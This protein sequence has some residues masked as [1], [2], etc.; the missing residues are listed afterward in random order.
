MANFRRIGALAGVL[1]SCLIASVAQS[2]RQ[3]WITS[4]A[5]A[6]VDINNSTEAPLFAA[7]GAPSHF[8][9]QTIRNIVHLTLGGEKIRVRLSNKFGT[10]PVTFNSVSVGLQA[11]GAQL[12]AISSRPVTF[13][14]ENS[15]TLPEGTEVFSDAIALPVKSGQNL[16][17]SLFTAGETGPAT[18]HAG[19]LQTNFIS[20]A[21]D[22]SA[23]ENAQSFGKTTQSWYFL[24]GVDVLPSQAGKGAIVALGDSITDGASARTDKNE[25]WTDVLAQ[26]LAADQRAYSV[27][28]AGIGGNRVLS[29][30]PCFGEN[31]IARLPRDVFGHFGVVAII[32]FEGTNDI[33][34]PDTHPPAE[35][36]PC[37]A[38]THV[39][40]EEIIAGYLQII[41]QAHARGIKV[42]GATILPFQGYRGWTAKGEATRVAVNNWIRS[43]NGFDGVIDF[44]LALRDPD[45]SAKFAPAYDSGDHLHPGPAGHKKMGE[46]VS[47]QLFP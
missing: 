7:S 24:Q 1:L 8:K 37:L 16:A 19:A 6:N 40:A 4:W 20:A 15:V 18:V 28:N 14:G 39:T 32:L 36:S 2:G 30:S 43:R 3:A 34:Q 25:R 42:F 21:G 9:N 26:R 27:L 10:Q 44:D 46:A 13:A 5:T 31:A 47:L 22:S 11:N 33:G 12:V 38:N 17:V 29:S 41:A 45:D 35:F 23:T